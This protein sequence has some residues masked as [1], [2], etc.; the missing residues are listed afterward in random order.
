MST[1]AS[2]YEYFAD[3]IRSRPVFN[4]FI[5]IGRPDTDP[6]QEQN[7][8]QVSVICECGGDPIPVSQPI[9]TGSGGLPIY[10]GNP[11][12]VNIPASEYSL[13]LQDKDRVQVYYSPNVTGFDNFSAEN[14]VT[15]AT[16]ADAIADTNINRQF[17]RTGDFTDTT[18]KRSSDGSGSFQDASGQ[19]WIDA[20]GQRINLHAHGC[21]CNG[22]TDD[23]N[24]MQALVDRYDNAV[25]HLPPGVQMA[26]D[27]KVTLTDNQKFNLNG[28]TVNVTGVNGGIDTLGTLDTA[29]NL[30]T[31]IDEPATTTISTATAHNLTVG[32]Y[33]FLQSCINCLSSDAGTD[34]LGYH[35]S[36]ISYLSE[37]LIVTEI[38]TTTQFEVRNGTIFRTYPLTPGSASGDR[39]ISFIQKVNF[40]ENVEIFNGIFEST[41]RVR[42]DKIQFTLSRNCH[43]RN[44]EVNHNQDNGASISFNRSY[45][46]TAENITGTHVLE[47]F[48]YL[49]IGDGHAYF[50]LN[51]YIAR[52]AQECSF[53]DCS[54][55][56]GTQCFDITYINGFNPSLNNTI[57]RF[58][59]YGASVNPVTTH[60]GCYAT[61][62]S[63]GVAYNSS[64]GSSI[65]SPNDVFINNVVYCTG[66]SSKF[67]TTNKYGVAIAGGFSDNVLIEGNAFYSPFRGITRIRVVQE[68][69]T[70]NLKVH[71]NTFYDVQSGVY[72]NRNEG[73]T[74]TEFDPVPATT[75]A[76][77][78]TTPAN[79]SIKDNTFYTR[80][81]FVL[82]DS[83]EYVNDIEISG[84]EVFG[85]D[86]TNENLQAIRI[87][88]NCQNIVLRNNNVHNSMGRTP[89]VRAASLTDTTT[90][91]TGTAHRIGIYNNISDSERPNLYNLTLVADNYGLLSPSSYAH[92]RI[93]TA[94]GTLDL[95]SISVFVFN[96]NS[97][98]TTISGLKDGEFVYLRK[99]SVN[100]TV[101]F[102]A[103]GNLNLEQ[104][105]SGYSIARTSD[106]VLAVR[107]RENVN[108]YL[109]A[110]G[111]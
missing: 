10:N 71:K 58:R 6:T 60:Q 76:T 85:E 66:E 92:T 59:T 87:R 29:I 46:C 37:F 94:S 8:I 25:F 105:G 98:I 97:T 56:N 28:S 62:I 40:T 4:G 79:L 11:A 38:L 110:A 31:A 101:T 108:I 45:L 107:I 54:S 43:A 19:W 72:Y 103:G 75:A 63:D 73:I 23:R 106:L 88:E 57:K 32:D 111:S 44:I 27:S 22:T 86:Y 100:N 49:G 64:R 65:R 83:P 18:F 21:A 2:P 7:Q 16:R 99:S 1:L 82:Y 33:V 30:A 42:S 41:A 78:T 26:L 84:N 93:G 47:D 35:V 39:T 12:Q 91:S 104:V 24:T 14:A 52:G 90:F 15:H 34:R 5:Y 69:I 95:T 74:E 50:T 51:D 96:D 55:V 61:V 48:D 102:N 53:L 67:P 109:I 13:T 3:P 77:A 20:A 80:S 17:I 9:R 89:F 81:N 36:D 68:S 70:S